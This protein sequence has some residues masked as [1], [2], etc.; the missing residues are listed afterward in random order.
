MDKFD[1]HDRARAHKDEVES[2]GA[3]VVVGGL[4]G[5]NIHINH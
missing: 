1:F 5:I 3:A 4:L 2:T